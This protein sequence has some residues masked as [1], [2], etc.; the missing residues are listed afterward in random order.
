[1]EIRN[2]LIAS[3]AGILILGGMLSVDGQTNRRRSTASTKPIATPTPVRA[4]PEVISRADQFLDENGRVITP[5]E[6]VIES[7]NTI[8]SPRPE[9]TVADL[10]L[11]LRSLESNK[12]IDSAEKQ[13]RLALNLD[14]LTKSEQR[15]ESLR[16]QYF[17]MVEKEAQIQQR[18]DT[19]ELETRPDAIDRSVA[20]A[21]S[22]R[23]EVLR[24][25]R[26]KTLAAERTKL[27]T[28]M[29]EVQKNKVNLD[30]NVQRAD[31]LVER[32]RTRLEKEIDEAL[33]DS[34]DEPTRVNP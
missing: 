11:R 19:L 21:G 31:S 34:G 6:P 32:L 12:K 30:L 26:Q 2:K 14:I 10:E 23:P 5:V 25:A 20:F 4:E 24:E 8:A 28:L 9:S 29:A 7:N 1:M 27:Q 16:K 15:V 3:A 33:L 17:E 22:L 13:R 18:L